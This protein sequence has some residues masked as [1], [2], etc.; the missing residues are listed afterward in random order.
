VTPGDTKAGLQPLALSAPWGRVPGTPSPRRENMG[1]IDYSIEKAG[2][3]PFWPCAAGT[4]STA[5][6]LDRTGR[7]TSNVR[8]GWMLASILRLRMG[9]RWREARSAWLPSTAATIPHPANARPDTSAFTHFGIHTLRHSH[10][11]AIHLPPPADLISGRSSSVYASRR[12]RRVLPSHRRTSTAR[13][14]SPARTGSRRAA[15]CAW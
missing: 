7:P 12:R 11:S 3:P 13:P 6:N 15:A 1:S 10:T 4:T 2:E 9:L 8:S 5:R 14:S